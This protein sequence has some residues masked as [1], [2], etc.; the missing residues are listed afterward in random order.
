ML[1]NHCPS[2]G[3]RI[4]S[5]CADGGCQ[6]AMGVLVSKRYLDQHAAVNNGVEK[7]EFIQIH[8]IRNEGAVHSSRANYTLSQVSA[9][10]SPS[11]SPW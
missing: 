8:I 3:L 4:E 9:I 11:Q 5:Q 7:L 1:A 10:R 6:W 2:S